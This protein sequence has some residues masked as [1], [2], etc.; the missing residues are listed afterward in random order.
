VFWWPFS[1]LAIP[2]EEILVRFSNGQNVSTNL[3]IHKA[4][5][6][7]GP[8]EIWTK[9]VLFSN[10]TV[11]S[12]PVPAKKHQSNTGPSSFQTPNYW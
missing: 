1:F 4:N 10:G 3:F 9:M 11:T 8:F 7:N 6:L 12:C 5:Q 2:K